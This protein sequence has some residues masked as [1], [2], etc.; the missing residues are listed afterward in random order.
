MADSNIFEF[1]EATSADIS[2]IVPL[3]NSA[4]RGDSSRAGWTTE[5]DLVSGDRVTISEV[6]SL[7][8]RSGV[9]VLLCLLHGKIIGTVEL[10]NNHP[11]AYLGMLVVQPRL[12]GAGIGK[13]LLAEA[14]RFVQQHWHSSSLCLSVI[15]VRTELIAYYE[16]RGYHSTAH[17]ED[18]PKQIGQS[19]PL[20]EGL[21]FAL[22]RKRLV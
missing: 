9:V 12:Q 18:F 16:R 1:R 5:A 13:Q 7:L 6:E 11:E 14:E 22:L 8:S 19:R 3:I 20:V 17:F 10:H 2:E 4:Y 21:K 15:S